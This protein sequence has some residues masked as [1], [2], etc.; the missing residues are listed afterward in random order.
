MNTR[1]FEPGDVITFAKAEIISNINTT[2]DILKISCH[3]RLIP[4]KLY[5]PIR[6]GKAYHKL[7][8]EK[9]GFGEVGYRKIGMCARKHELLAVYNIKPRFAHL[10]DTYVRIK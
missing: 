9:I 2:K 6:S 10:A 7:P 8:D 1:R 4:E 5:I 3:Y